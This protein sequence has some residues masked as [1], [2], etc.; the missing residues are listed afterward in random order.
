MDH[1]AGDEG[2]EDVCLHGV[3]FNRQRGTHRTERTFSCYLCLYAIDRKPY[4]TVLSVFVERI[5][6]LFGCA[7]HTVVNRHLSAAL[8]YAV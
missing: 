3:T 1:I 2:T 4:R 6:G 8:R 5:G 7:V